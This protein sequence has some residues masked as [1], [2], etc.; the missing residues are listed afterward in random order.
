MLKSINLLLLFIF[1]STVLSQHKL[2]TLKDKQSLEP[3]PFATI[4]TNFNRN[5]ISNEEGHFRLTKLNAFTQTDSVFISC[6]GYQKRREAILALK[7]SIVFL[8]PKVIELNAIILTQNNLSASDIIEKVKENLQSKYNF[9]LSKKRFFSRS[10][11]YQ[12]W[13]KRK[14]EVKKSSIASLDQGFFKQLRK[15]IPKSDAYH[16]EIVGDWSGDWSAKQHKLEIL[17]AVNLADTLNQKGY[18]AIENAFDQILNKNVKEDSYFKFKSG[19]FSTKIARDEFIEKEI[20]SSDVEALKKTMTEK[21]NKRA[22]QRENFHRAKKNEL[23]NVL[24][25]IISKEK[26]QLNV[27]EKSNRF[28]FEIRSFEYLND[29]PIYIISFKPKTN[30]AKFVGT[31]YV[32]ADSFAVVQIDY[33]NVSDLKNIALF[34]FSYQEYF[35]SI[36]LKFDPFLSDKLALQFCE[37]VT[38]YRTGIKRPLKIIEKNKVVKGRRKQNE[39]LLDLD[40]ELDQTD[41]F[42]LVV[43][44][45]SPIN[46]KEYEVL[47]IQK[48]YQP[49]KH[50]AYDA[51]FWEGFDI[52][53]PNEAIR[54]FKVNEN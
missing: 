18:D 25:S 34:G 43:F 54:N 46:G 20:D 23:I 12:D 48:S 50:H 19:I 27:F 47:E 8:Q 6:M 14:I 53:S 3:I 11:F 21:Q 22:K 42:T 36:K 17:K 4:T 15:L 31:I 1:S 45:H 26:W 7:D 13:N 5:L 10:S 52:I 28:S 32:N 38:S 2:I 24:N 33:T 49:E 29:Q 44:D 35:R 51:T 39:L 30:K 9:S 40:F 41:Q 16:T 37:L